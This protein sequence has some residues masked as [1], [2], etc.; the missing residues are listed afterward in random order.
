MGGYYY[1]YSFT[2]TKQVEFHFFL[3][4]S[5]FLLVLCLFIHTKDQ[6]GD[7]PTEI[8][9]H[10]NGETSLASIEEWC[11][12]IR[13]SESIQLLG[14][15]ATPRLSRALKRIS[16]KSKAV[17]AENRRCQLEGFQWRS[18]FLQ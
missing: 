12:T 18:V 2:S 4:L 1:Y 11:Q 10:L 7:T 14:I 3:F 13:Q 5:S 17:C 16:D 15:H 9:R 6:K 8:C